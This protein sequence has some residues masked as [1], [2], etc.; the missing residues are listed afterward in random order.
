[1]NDPDEPLVPEARDTYV[2]AIRAGTVRLP[3]ASLE[4]LLNRYILPA[5]GAPLKDARLS[6]SGDRLVL[7]GKVHRFRLDLPITLE[8]Q[9]AIGTDGMIEL[10]PEHIAVSEVGVGGMFKLF[11]LELERLIDLPS[12]GP[13]RILGNQITIDPVQIFPAPRAIGHPSTVRIERGELVLE[14]GDGD[15]PTPPPLLDEAPNYLMG[16]G[17]DLVVGRML[18]HDACFQIVNQEPSKHLDFSLERYR[19]QLGR[20]ASS[21]RPGDQLLVRLPNLDGPLARSLAD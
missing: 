7:R 11:K 16:V 4:A 6:I 13:F 5:V 20:G 1:M 12:G 8:S 19:E 18:M 9:V 10:L 2:F 3:A 15:R 14:Y 17:H 21:L